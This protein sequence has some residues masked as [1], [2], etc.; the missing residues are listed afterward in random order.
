MCM[1][2]RELVTFDLTR[3]DISPLEGHD[4]S[5]ETPYCADMANQDLLIDCQDHELFVKVLALACQMMEL[6]NP[7]KLACAINHRYDA[8]GHLIGCIVTVIP[9]REYQQ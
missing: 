7:Q 2:D 1:S 6:A 4:W 8:R 3:A 9:S 5:R